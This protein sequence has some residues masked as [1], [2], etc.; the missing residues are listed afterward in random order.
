MF[1]EHDIL[2]QLEISPF[3]IILDVEEMSK[4]S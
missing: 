1:T 4:L 3:M 2:W